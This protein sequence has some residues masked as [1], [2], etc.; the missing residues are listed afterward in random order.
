MAA[1]GWAPSKGSFSVSYATQ[2]FTKLVLDRV[3]GELDL[4]NWRSGYDYL[5][6][7]KRGEQGVSDIGG[8]K[9]TSLRTVSIL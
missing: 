4:K 8:W 3:G 5:L 6:D 2:T 1:P 9:E 7:S